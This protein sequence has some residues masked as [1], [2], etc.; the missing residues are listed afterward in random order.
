MTT[1]PCPCGAGQSYDD[2]CGRYHRGEADAPTAETLMRSR[3]SAFAVGDVA[4]LGDT[5]HPSTR[6]DRPEPDADRRWTRL[7]VRAT[8]GG[9]VFDTRGTVLFEAHYEAGGRSGVQREESEFVR[10]DRRWYYVG[11]ADP[12]R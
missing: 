11:E 10:E 6:P 3:Y 1:G 2:C 5:W 9:G 7:D 12:A 8:S 4:Y